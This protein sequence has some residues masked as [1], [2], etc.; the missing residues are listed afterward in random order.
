MYSSRQIS[1]LESD[2]DELIQKISQS[3]AHSTELQKE[4]ESQQEQF[5]K[6]RDRETKL[7]SAYDKVKKSLTDANSTVSTL[8]ANNSE[9]N[10]QV[11]LTIYLIHQP[12][13]IVR[14]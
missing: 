7:K 4:L 3:H 5:N 10:N 6:Q 2:K 9:L 14:T 1:K 11:L 8:N 13:H 12:H